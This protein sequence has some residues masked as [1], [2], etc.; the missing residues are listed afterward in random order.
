MLACSVAAVVSER[1]AGPKRWTVRCAGYKSLRTVSPSFAT[2]QLFT[3]RRFSEVVQSSGPHN[4][5]ETTR[6]L[7]GTRIARTLPTSIPVDPTERRPGFIRR[8]R[9]S[10]KQHTRG[11]LFE[12]TAVYQQRIWGKLG[13]VWLHPSLPFRNVRQQEHCKEL[14]HKSDRLVTYKD[15]RPRTQR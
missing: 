9:Y 10:K 11:S 6:R 4:E 13:Y 15:L 2:A 1:R 12:Q 5:R 8:A 7:V 14:K 3:F